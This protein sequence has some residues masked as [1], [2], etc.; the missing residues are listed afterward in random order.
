MHNIP[1]SALAMH[2]QQGP[3]AR[4]VACNLSWQFSTEDTPQAQGISVPIFG[5]NC[6]S[7]PL[8]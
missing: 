5:E 4:I 8:T 1:Y 3:D 6:P 2:L 7:K